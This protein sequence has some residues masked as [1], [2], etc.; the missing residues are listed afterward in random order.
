MI[1]STQRAFMGPWKSGRMK[2]V[3]FYSC[4]C[5]FIRK[6][7]TSSGNDYSQTSCKHTGLIFRKTCFH[8][9]LI[10]FVITALLIYIL[11]VNLNLDKVFSNSGIFGYNS[12]SF[13]VVGKV[14]L[15]GH[16][17]TTAFTG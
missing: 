4:I 8:K 6:Q 10:Y 2:S 9:N 7:D 12:T 11:S 13:F 15:T 3:I 1:K 14:S 17:I 5:L 16:S